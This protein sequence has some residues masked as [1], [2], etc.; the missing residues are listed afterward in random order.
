MTCWSWSNVK[1]DFTEPLFVSWCKVL[2]EWGFVDE[3]ESEGAKIVC[4]SFR[5]T[6]NKNVFAGIEEQLVNDESRTNP[7]LTNSAKSL[8]D[9]SFRSVLHVIRDFI[10]YGCWLWEVQLFPDKK[11]EVPEV[12]YFVWKVH[13]KFLGYLVILQ[14]PCLFRPH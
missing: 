3:S 12:L 7:R 9:S 13:G 6:D 14:P 5:S 10:L 4:S 8:D 1:R 11:Q 2:E